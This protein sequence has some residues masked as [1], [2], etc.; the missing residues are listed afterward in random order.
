M[1]RDHKASSRSH[2]SCHD[3]RH[4]VRLVWFAVSRYPFVIETEPEKMPDNLKLFCPG[5]RA[6]SAHVAEGVQIFEL[7]FI[8]GLYSA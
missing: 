1:A 5:P 7:D 3:L 4:F 2:R 8:D 6:S